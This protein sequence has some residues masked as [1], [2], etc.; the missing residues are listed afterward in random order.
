VSG[1]RRRI[2]IVEDDSARAD[3][4]LRSFEGH[5]DRFD[6]ASVGSL[7]EA[8]ARL[9][10]W[11]PDLVLCEFALGDGAV[12]ELLRLAGS[13]P[14]PVI[15]VSDAPYVEAA[16]E[17]MKAGASGCVPLC[18][19]TLA[20]LPDIAE[21]TLCRWGETFGRREPRSASAEEERLR[22]LI[23]NINAAVV[24]HDA[25]TRIIA[26]NRA[27]QE[28]LGLPEGGFLGISP[29]NLGYRLYRENGTPLPEQERPILRVLN[30]RRSIRGMA[31]GIQPQGRQDV[32]WV[33]VNAD[34]LLDATGR[35]TQI[36]IVF[37]DITERRAYE[38][39]LRRE[40]H[41]AQAYLDVAGTLFVALN[42][43]GEITLLNKTAC[44]LLGCRESDVLGRNWFDTFL[45]VEQRHQIKVLFAK[46]IAGQVA[47]VEYVENLV[48]TANGERR[49]IAWH[50]TVL[51]DG[52][53]AV[54]ASVSSGEDITDR[55]RD[56]E[57]IRHLNAVLLA[58]R[59]INQLI[60]WE[61]DRDRLLQGVCDNL[62]RTRGYASAW[63]IILDAAGVPT[64]SAEAGVGEGFLAV[65][66]CVRRGAPPECARRAL[67][68]EDV[69]TI[70]D[71]RET[72]GD[73]PLVD[74]ATDSAGMITRLSY[75]GKVYGVLTV[76]IPARLAADGE[77]QVLFGE[78][79]ADIA[80]ALHGID[81]EED[82]ERVVAA[83]RA[84]EQEHREIFE[85]VAD[86]LLIFDE[87]SKIVEANPAACEMYGYDHKELIGRTGRDIIHPAHLRVLEQ[88]ERC[89]ATGERFVIEAVDVRKDG[90]AFNVEVR[91]ATVQFRGRRH[92]LSA[93]RDISDRKR[94]NAARQ[95]LEAKMQQA[96]KLESL[97]V[98]AGGVAHDFNNLLTGILG[99]ASL[100][101]MDLPHGSP[102]RHGLEQIETASKRA[103]DLTNQMLAYSGKGR[104]VVE[105]INLSRLVEETADLFRS[106]ISKKVALR[107]DLPEAL[108]AIRADA[109]QVRQVVM[110][111]ITNASDAIGDRSGLITVR[112][113]V[114]TV[115]WEYL[116]TTYLDDALPEGDYVYVEVGD[117]GCG[118]DEATKAKI[119]DPFFTTKFTGR[120]LGLAAVLG[121]VRGHQGAIKVYSEIGRGTTFRV[122]F[123]SSDQPAA[124]VDRAADAEPAWRGHGTILVIDDEETVRA[125]ASR[126]LEQIGFTVHAARN[127]RQGLELLTRHADDVVLALLDLTMPD[128]N[129][130]EAFHELRRI[131]PDVRVI[132]SSGY[133]EQ[134]ATAQFAGEGLAGFIQKPY[135]AG[136]LITKIRDVL[137]P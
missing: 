132:L 118:M 44:R 114:M 80:F 106:A 18:D 59:N 33:F 99:N 17:T 38:E 93:A 29:L 109:T 110:N 32:T 67:E 107:C 26:A 88:Y 51:R 5:G 122:L 34:P 40:K 53:G 8:E 131:R 134:D 62:V 117:T 54:T 96:Q 1:R 57:R 95:R 36:I 100:I 37:M 31:V 45:P 130:Q 14:T 2:L 74:N 27:A 24:L 30:T 101:L 119:F 50:N 77:E 112:T 75:G 43:D 108:P 58:I 113:G 121:I 12:R 135:N 65:A 41:R 71:R 49:L 82:H 115:D 90:S 11:R 25:E 22:L 3:R 52:T 46:L 105:P 97:G 9:R 6:A 20:A 123:P 10:D 120:G 125:V 39:A 136:S 85:S 129:G 68:L 89:L 79:A 42:R 124:E 55:R 133:T 61:K 48:V 94:A 116:G 98:L 15:V 92:L 91:G 73:C 102:A 104:F 13:T 83:L 76:S 70:L 16:I 56:E 60:A 64:R 86:A 84:S 66:E 137:E 19:Q 72:C 63:A 111:L 21:G 7:A 127:G 103:A 4:V 126:V 87:E 35:V 69:V 23:D 47:P 28:M 78:L 128:M 81:V